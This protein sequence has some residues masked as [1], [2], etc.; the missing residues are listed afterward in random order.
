MKREN[1]YKAKDRMTEMIKKTKRSRQMKTRIMEDHGHGSYLRKENLR[2]RDDTPSAA[3]LVTYLI[4][5]AVIHLRLS[6]RKAKTTT[7]TH[8]S[9]H[10]LIHLS[11]K[12]ICCQ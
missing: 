5:R 8:R 2:E 11:V 12:A 10:R 1:E 4:C 7:L 6:C 9:F 3:L